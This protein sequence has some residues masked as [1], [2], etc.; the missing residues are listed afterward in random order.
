MTVTLKSSIGA[1]TKDELTPPEAAAL[2]VSA[3]ERRG[4]RF[5]V[6]DDDGRF[7]LH[8]DGVPDITNHDEAEVVSTIVLSL[9]AEI[10]RV[11]LAQRVLH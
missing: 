2:L 11:L 9:R 6:L 3:L 10:R 8:L 5:E 4:A 1:V 7:R